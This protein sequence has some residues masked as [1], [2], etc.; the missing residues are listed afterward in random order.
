[1]HRAFEMPTP[2]LVALLTEHLRGGP[3]N[4]SA[5]CL[6]QRQERFQQIASIP[7]R[8]AET[9]P[10]RALVHERRTLVGSEVVQAP[11][12]YNITRGIVYGIQPVDHLGLTVNVPLGDMFSID[13]G[14]GKSLPSRIY[15]RVYCSNP[16]TPSIYDPEDQLIQI[17]KFFTS[18]S[19]PLRIC[20]IFGDS[21]LVDFIPEE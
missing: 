12:N 17:V 18:C 19:E 3:G 10:V 8:K 21:M 1:M 9:Q 16:R 7:Q 15:I 6:N 13:A 14:P 11:A 5:P 20:D 4:N 2:L